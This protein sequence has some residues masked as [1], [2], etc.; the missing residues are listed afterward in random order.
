VTKKVSLDDLLERGE[1]NADLH[2]DNPEKRRWHKTYRTPRNRLM[3]L[4]GDEYTRPLANNPAQDI[5][6]Q[7]LAREFINN[8]M[9]QT[10]AYAAVYGVPLKK[11]SSPASKIFNSTWMKAKIRE[12]LLG[13]DGKLEDELPKEYLIERYMQMID[14]NILDYMADDGTYLSVT[15]LKALP[16]WAQQQIKR[17]SIV[18]ETV[19]LVVRDQHGEIRRNDNGE[20]AYVEVRKQH[21]TIELYDKQK[22]M[23]NLAKVMKWINDN[24]DLSVNLIGPDTM[25]RA[26]S[27]VKQLRRESLEGTAKRITSD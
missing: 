2:K 8:G 15:E 22:A 9:N 26:E 10:K 3:H 12:Y 25:V 1:S 20:P 6:Y 17:L 13:E 4:R 11:A 19:P 7:E 14:N 24:V 23:E 16:E 18:N 27:R 5:R 21:V